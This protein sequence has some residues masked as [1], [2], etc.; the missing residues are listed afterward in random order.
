M[1]VVVL[2]PGGAGK[3]TFAR[4]VAAG[5]G[6]PYV[7][8]DREFWSAGLE[9]LPPAAWAARQEALAAP[10]AWVL[11]GDLGPYDVVEAR[12]RRADTVVVLDLPTRVCAWRALRRSRQRR[13]FWWWLLTWRRRYR[14]RLLAAARR[15]APA[16]ELIVVR[17]PRAVA[18]L[19]ADLGARDGRAG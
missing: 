16:A 13:D 4:A 17:R 8:L 12:L 6:V 1:R 10:G 9:P 19:A 18:R 2:G 14:P 11:D 7:E 15:H 5:A 3:S